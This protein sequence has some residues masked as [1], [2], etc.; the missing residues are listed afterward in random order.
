MATIPEQVAWSEASP[1]AIDEAATRLGRYLSQKR[2]LGTNN[3]YLRQTVSTV[4]KDA[5]DPQSQANDKHLSEYVA[6]SAVLHSGDG[7]SYL[8]RALG[9]LM[10][11]DADIARHLGYYAE[12]RGALSILASQGVGVFTNRNVVVDAQG[13]V[14]FFAGATHSVTWPA[15]DH[16]A[17]GPKGAASLS[18]V[19]SPASLPLTDWVA[20]LGLGENAWSPVGRDWLRAW[21]V[22]LKMFSRDR[23]ARNEASYRPSGLRGIY[24][25]DASD[26]AKFVRELWTVLSP[27]PGEPFGV[28]DRHILRLTLERAYESTTGLE[29]AGAKAFKAVLR[30]S[31]RSSGV[32]KN[33]PLGQFLLRQIEPN[34]PLLIEE[35]RG[36]DTLLQPGHHRQVLARAVLLLRL[37]TGLARAMLERASLAATDL[38][39]WTSSLAERHGICEPGAL[40]V[41][42]ADLWI[43]VEE[44]LGQFQ[45]L[46]ESQRGRFFQGLIREPVAGI[47][48]L[49]GCERIALW[50]LA[51]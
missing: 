14:R 6:A 41:D 8:G 42:P 30:N 29:A 39:F 48:V 25:P 12:L 1:D 45:T 40:P 44:A 15:L 31:L 38:R 13:Q 7:W 10:R 50:S 26:D 43:D 27:S 5:N 47:E 21:G 46:S 49:A 20:A 35:S 28:L 2:W 22:D 11:G 9:A 36:R 17:D 24:S 51:A 3:R 32:D 33:S 16:W 34:D 18:E 4:I 19:V 23:A 37:S